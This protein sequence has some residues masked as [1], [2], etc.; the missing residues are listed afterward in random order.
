MVAL[1]H[2]LLN[3]FSRD[4]VS[5][6]LYLASTSNFAFQKVPFCFDL[7]DLCGRVFKLV[8]LRVVQHF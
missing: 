3:L 7:L 4:L 1:E 2:T 5:S 8:Y 6:I